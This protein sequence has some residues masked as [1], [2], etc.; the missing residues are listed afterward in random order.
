MEEG[1]EKTEQQIG[2]TSG[3]ILLFIAK[4]LK[5]YCVVAKSVR[6]KMRT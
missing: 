3:D 1:K 6:E 5:Q 2:R 4:V